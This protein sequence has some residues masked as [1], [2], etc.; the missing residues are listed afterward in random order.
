MSSIT[1][2]SIK[3]W[4]MAIKAPASLR[5]DPLVIATAVTGPGIITPVSDM[6]KTERRNNGRLVVSVTMILL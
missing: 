5:C 1:G 4:P 6:A 3:P 2:S